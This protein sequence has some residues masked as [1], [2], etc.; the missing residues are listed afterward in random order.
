M[1]E[2]YLYFVRCLVFDEGV[3]PD[4]ILDLLGTLKEM[5]RDDVIN[6]KLSQTGSYCRTQKEKFKF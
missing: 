2:R 6:V 5:V 4:N 3:E 1:T